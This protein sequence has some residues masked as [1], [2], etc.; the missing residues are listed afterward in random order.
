VILIVNSAIKHLWEIWHFWT[1][2]RYTGDTVRVVMQQAGWLGNWN[3]VPRRHNISCLPVPVPFWGSASQWLM[4][5]LSTHVKQ[6]M[7]EADHA[8]LPSVKVNNAYFY[9]LVCCNDM[10][11]NGAVGK[12]VEYTVSEWTWRVMF[13]IKR[14]QKWWLSIIGCHEYTFVWGFQN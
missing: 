1:I 9:C 13:T 11:H 3:W 4:G 12:F 6:P 14:M 8:P 7:R 10:G 5:T 2:D